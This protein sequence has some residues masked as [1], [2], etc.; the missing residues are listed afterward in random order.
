MTP[1][2]L[3]PNPIV[4]RF[5]CALFGHNDAPVLVAVS[6][7]ELPL[8]KPR[9]TFSVVTLACGRCLR[10]AQVSVGAVIR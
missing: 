7:I 9:S 4:A 10:V 6:K 2:R 5:V 3:A 1:L 8:D